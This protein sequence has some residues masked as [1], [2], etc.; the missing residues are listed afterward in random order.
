MMNMD[1]QTNVIAEIDRLRQDNMDMAAILDREEIFYGHTNIY[2]EVTR[3]RCMNLRLKATMDLQQIDDIG[4]RHNRPCI[5][6]RT[7]QADSTYNGSNKQEISRLSTGI[8]NHGERDRSTLC[9]T[10]DDASSEDRD[11]NM[12]SVRESPS[13][14][15][16]MLFIVHPTRSPSG[17]VVTYDL[18]E[19]VTGMDLY[20]CLDKRNIRVHVEPIRQLYEED[21]P[22]YRNILIEDV[23]IREIYSSKSSDMTTGNPIKEHESSLAVTD[24]P[25]DG[26]NHLDIPFMGVSDQEGQGDVSKLDPRGLVSD[27]DVT[28]INQNQEQ[29]L[30]AIVEQQRYADY[31]ESCKTTIH[32]CSVVI[33]MC[34]NKIG[35]PG[36]DFLT[37][38]VS[39][40]DGPEHSKPVPEKG[41]NVNFSENETLGSHKQISYTDV[42]IP[43]NIVSHENEPVESSSLEVTDIIEDAIGNRHLPIP[44]KVIPYGHRRPKCVPKLDLTGLASESDIDVAKISGY[45]ISWLFPGPNTG[46]DA[47]VMSHK[48]SSHHHEIYSSKIS[49]MKTV[50]PTKE[51]ESSLAM[52][53][54]PKDDES[55][56]DL[57]FKLASSSDQERPNGVSK[58]DLRGLV[59]DSDINIA[60]VDENTEPELVANV[61]EQRYADYIESCKTT[62]HLCSVV[63]EMCANKIG[64]PGQDS[65]TQN[66]S[67][68]DHP[69]RSSHVEEE[70]KD[71][72]AMSPKKVVSHGNEPVESSS[73]EVTDIIEDVIGNRHL[74]IPFKVIPYDHRR[75]KCVPKLDLTGLASESDIDVAKISGYDISWLFPGPNT[76]NDASVMS[77]KRSSQHHEIFQSRGSDMSAENPIGERD[78]SLANT[79]FPKDKGSNLNIPFKRVSSSDQDRPNGVS[80]LQQ[81]R[82][83]PVFNLDPRGM[84]SDFDINIGRFDKNTEPE[85]VADVEAQRYAD[86]IEYCKATIHLCSVIIEKCA[87][88]IGNSWQVAQVP[89]EVVSHGNEL[90]ESH[91]LEVT[92]IIEDVIGNRHLPIPFK[93]VPYGHR[94][95]KCVPKLD[96]TGLASESD[97]DVAKISGYDISWLFPDPNTGNDATGKQHKRKPYL[98]NSSIKINSANKE[99]NRYMTSP[100]KGNIKRARVHFRDVD[101]VI[102]DHYLDDRDDVPCIDL[103]QEVSSIRPVKEG[104]IVKEF[105]SSDD[106]SPRDTTLDCA[107]ELPYAGL[108]KEDLMNDLPRGSKLEESEFVDDDVGHLNLNMS[109]ITIPGHGHQTRKNPYKKEICFQDR[110]WYQIYRDPG[111]VNVKSRY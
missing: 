89:K 63:I 10:D 88:K 33:E 73:L 35:I 80:K 54:I 60:R 30:V 109:A 7:T 99:R 85:L 36:Q 9:A 13:E 95:P 5:R 97:I 27:S 24:I 59:S 20:G 100:N 102:S 1:I 55:H 56:L 21:I 39:N 92:D 61:E 98:K 14:T 42:Q 96:L 31:I 32:L 52:T 106:E 105:L 49:G 65:W 93:V 46:N 6:A 108:E 71:F 69:E 101:S 29:D 40:M 19:D 51:H 107:P 50:S 18:P 72:D 45:D 110:T 58:L 77:H 38:N 74:P 87:D 43:K 34:A 81:D 48:R 8:S 22:H 90:V 84:V 17:T 12:N 53:D 82:P 62:I 66:V 91:S 70:R 47:S 111:D 76:G 11:S 64:I 83:D 78:S 44:F 75:P 16:E 94:R 37:K 67:N 68:I 25:T 2:E 15:E 103:S 86:Y 57:P 79:N 41:S 26:D 23:E 3:L 4:K 28:R 104:H